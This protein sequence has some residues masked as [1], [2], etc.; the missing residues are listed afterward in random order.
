MAT[1]TKEE[2]IAAKGVTRCPTAFVGH[3]H[4]ANPL[5]VEDRLALREHAKFLQSLQKGFG[6]IKKP[7]L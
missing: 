6:F 4:S 2:F 5:S 1:L 3:T 7:T